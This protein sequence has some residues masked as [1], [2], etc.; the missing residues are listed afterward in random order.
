MSVLK[1]FVR[2]VYQ[3]ESFNLSRKDYILIICIISKPDVIK[4]NAFGLP[5]TFDVSDELNNSNIVSLP[6]PVVPK[7][8]CCAEH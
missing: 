1:A 5:P 3:R 4:P 2:E 7:R 6:K 8:F